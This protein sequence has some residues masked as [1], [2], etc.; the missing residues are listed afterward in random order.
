[1]GSLVKR[2]DSITFSCE[3]LSRQGST[4]RGRSIRGRERGGRMEHG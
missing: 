3:D 2:G 1:M 4:E